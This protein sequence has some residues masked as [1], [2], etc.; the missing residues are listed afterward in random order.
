MKLTEGRGFLWR[1]FVLLLCLMMAAIN[2]GNNLL[3]LV[4]SVMVAVAIVSWFMGGR[5]LRR[6]TARLEM[7]EEVSAGSSF[8]LGV[9]AKARAGKLPAPWADA[10]VKGF[11]NQAPPL[12]IPALGPG[13]R[14]FVCAPIRLSRRGI[15]RNFKLILHSRYPFGLFKRKRRVSSDASIVVTPKLHPISSLQMDNP[16]GHGKMRLTQVGEGADLFNIREYTTRDDARRIDW[17]AS[18]RLAT[19]ML[20]EFE[21][22]S[23]RILEVILDERPGNGST[24]M[25]NEIDAFERLVETAASILHHCEGKGIRGRLLVPGMKDAAR[26]MEG[27]GAMNYLATAQPRSGTPAPDS[28]PGMEMIPR[29]ILSLDPSSQSRFDIEWATPVPAS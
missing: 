9:E 3:Y 1:F 7:P 15:H 10:V 14:T 12:F 23:E 28:M 19:P 17:K 8:L 29:I 21:R 20:K 27:R 11:P 2:T 26:G 22:E 13:G 24:G 18:A 4:L 5:S 6:V 25:K 16:A